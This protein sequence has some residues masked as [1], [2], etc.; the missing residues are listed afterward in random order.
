MNCPRRMINTMRRGRRLL[1]FSTVCMMLVSSGV[2]PVRAQDSAPPDL[3]MLLN[4]DLFRSQ[5]QHGEPGWP[6]SNSSDSTL[7]QIRTLN[8]LGYLGNSK[9]MDTVVGGGAS[10]GL[11][12][13]APPSSQETPE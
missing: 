9:H 2:L 1:S 7:D 10:G 4:L 13:P 5:L 11:K 12:P 3:Q 8:A 6:S